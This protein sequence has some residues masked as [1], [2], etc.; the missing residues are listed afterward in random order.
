MR[1]R[2]AGGGALQA[3]RSP[4]TNH[5]GSNTGKKTDLLP[6]LEALSSSGNFL[7]ISNNE[8][9][10]SLRC[11]DKKVHSTVRRVHGVEWDMLFCDVS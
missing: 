9:L 8:G 11:E 10:N 1:V 2:P 5:T 7:N 6:V 3:R 4:F